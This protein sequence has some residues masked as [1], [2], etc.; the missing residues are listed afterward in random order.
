M[1]PELS[2]D[3][4]RLA[5]AISESRAIRAQ[6]AFFLDTC[7]RHPLSDEECISELRTLSRLWATYPPY[8]RLERE[9]EN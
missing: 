9:D 1:S 3:H 8:V 4:D 5:L 7:L 6:S 2:E